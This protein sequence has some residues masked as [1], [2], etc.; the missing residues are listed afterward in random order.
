MTIPKTGPKNAP[1]VSIIDK[2]PTWLKIESQNP[3]TNKAIIPI[4][5]LDE[6]EFS[7]LGAKLIREYFE[8]IKFAIKFVEAVAKNIKIKTII[9]K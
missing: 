6:F 2:A 3:P 5:T 4:N 8:G 9:V 7:V 1:I